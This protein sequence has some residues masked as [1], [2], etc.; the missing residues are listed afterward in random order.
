METLKQV[1]REEGIYKDSFPEY[2]NYALSGTSAET[3]F[4]SRNAARLREIRDK[5]D[6]ER[7]MD[8]AGGFEI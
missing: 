4:G 6:P 7:V 1:G 8:L 2:P 5:I 3:L